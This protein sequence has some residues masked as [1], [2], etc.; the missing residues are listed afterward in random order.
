VD[1]SDVR[2]GRVRR[3]GWA[4]VSHGLYRTGGNAAGVH[5][6]LRAWQLVLPGSGAFTHLTAAAVYGWWLPPLPADVPV[7]AGI[8]ESD[9]RPRR[10]G[11]VVCR[12]TQPVPTVLRGGLRLA[13]PGEALRAA[14]RDLGLLDLVVLVDSALQRRHCDVGELRRVSA[15]RR[16]GAPALRKALGFVDARSESP[17][18]SVLRM[19]HWVCD[20]PVEPQYEVRDEFGALVGRGD[21]WIVG[22]QRLH[23]YDG[24]VHRTIRGQARD[25]SRDRALRRIGW[26]RYGYTNRDL[27]L[28]ATSVL[29]DAD[30]ALGRPHRP[31]RVRAWHRLLAESRLT[32]AGTTRL[33]RRW[34][35]VDDETGHE[36]PA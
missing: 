3:S 17:W 25:L 19:L 26:E 36:R 23:E 8:A 2:L 1:S 12:H 16:R 10:D 22:T 34:G 4:R 21:L 33:R 9:N 7:F 13:T 24:D 30:A 35:L 15:R 18:E 31:R 27:L 20:I 29:R 6:D 28:H 14:G 5:A 11:L 32:A